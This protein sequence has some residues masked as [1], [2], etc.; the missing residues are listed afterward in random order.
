MSDSMVFISR[1]VDAAPTKTSSF[2][3]PL[4]NREAHPTFEIN[5][6]WFPQDMAKFTERLIEEHSHAHFVSSDDKGDF[7]TPGVDKTGPAGVKNDVFS[8]SCTEPDGRVV[9]WLSCKLKNCRRSRNIRAEPRWGEKI[10]VQTLEI[11]ESI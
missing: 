6:P 10:L 4:V 3:G 2:T 7:A 8:I 11:L 1:T 5:S 9:K